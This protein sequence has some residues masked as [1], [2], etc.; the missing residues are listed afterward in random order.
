MLQDGTVAKAT[1]F[2]QETLFDWK[3]ADWGNND[4]IYIICTQGERGSWELNWTGNLCGTPLKDILSQKPYGIIVE[5]IPLSEN[6]ENDMWAVFN[7]VNELLKRE[8][9]TEDC[10]VYLDVTNVYRSF[11][12]LVTTLLQF[13]Q[14]MYNIIPEGIYYG[15]F[16]RESK[17]GQIQDLTSIIELQRCVEVA[18]GLTEYGRLN[19]LA[20][21]LKENEDL[22]YIGDSIQLLDEALSTGLGDALRKS[23]FKTTFDQSIRTVKSSNLSEP[24]K[25]VLLSVFGK[26]NDF[27]TNGQIE[28]ILAAARWAF[29]HR[30]VA[31]AYT[32]GKEYINRKAFKRLENMCPYH[33]VNSSSNLEYVNRVLVIK[34]KDIDDNNF[35][36]DLATY[37]DNTTYILSLKWVQDLRNA[38]YGQFNDDRNNIDHCKPNSGMTYDILYDRFKENFEMLV[39]IVQNAPKSPKPEKKATQPLVIS[40][41]SRKREW[42]DKEINAAISYLN[43]DDNQNIL[44]ISQLEIPQI[45]ETKDKDDVKK[46]ARQILE[47]IKKISEPRYCVIHIAEE[48]IFTFEIVTQLKSRGYRCLALTDA[49]NKQSESCLFMEY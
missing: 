22:K 17:T 15:L 18:N 12:V 47:D 24:I 7:Q 5:A 13:A 36:G 45:N 37:I 38:N 14:F 16:D 9:K 44:S 4:R 2:F 32:L 48:P 30:M 46:L 8:E 33:G 6:S 10:H 28:N 1:R 41:E 27:K 43:L 39:S 3:C 49:K 31:M 20:D 29:N 40:I 26:L 19:K 34:Q 11:P 23:S 42:S 21:L 35:K 25:Q